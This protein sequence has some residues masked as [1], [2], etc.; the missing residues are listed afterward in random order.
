MTNDPPRVRLK[1]IALPPEHGSWGFLFEPILLALLVAPSLSG[2]A[3][4]VAVVAAF[5]LRNP[6]RIFLRAH[7]RGAGSPRRAMARRVA[8]VYAAVTGAGGTACVASA[9]VGAVWPL[10]VVSPL[11]A[12][13]VLYDSRNRGR[14]LS[15][16]FLGPVVLAAAAPSIALS[17]GWMTPAAMVLWV[18][19]VIKA[20]PTV[21]YVRA[22]LGLEDGR[23]SPA[24]PALLAH[25]VAT[26]IAAAMV[27]RGLAPWPVLAASIV[28]A[29]RAGLG[30][31]AA[32]VFH[33]P[34]QIGISE[35]VY[36]GMYVAAVTLGYHAGR[37]SAGEHVG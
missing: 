22:R 32:R 37:W 15:A 33:T 24:L 6:L 23:R 12:A 34:K 36:S 18:I 29:A 13:Y 2:A 20:I 4:A 14:T 35:F 27:R 26:V 5:L 9:G 1:P 8:L 31:S 17:A 30:L 16:E 10:L 25:V 19:V 7:G 11:G 21:V 28:L 3:L